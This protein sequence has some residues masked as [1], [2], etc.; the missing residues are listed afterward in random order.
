MLSTQ[1]INN[2]KL[3]AD[4][5]TTTIENEESSSADGSSDTLSQITQ[6]VS[7]AAELFGGGNPLGFVA[8]QV[9]T[10]KPQIFHSGGNLT[11]DISTREGCSPERMYQTAMGA[12]GWGARRRE[13]AGMTPRSKALE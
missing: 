13:P 7:T 3:S 9:F 11:E 8:Q 2:A 10:T 1:G 6:L 4:L 12:M 5:I